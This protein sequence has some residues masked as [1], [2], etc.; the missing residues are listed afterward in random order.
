MDNSGANCGGGGGRIHCDLNT[1]IDGI[2][3]IVCHKLPMILAISS[4]IQPSLGGVDGYVSGDLIDVGGP[5]R[6]L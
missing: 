4:M 3:S 1:T 2:C 6:L 5:A